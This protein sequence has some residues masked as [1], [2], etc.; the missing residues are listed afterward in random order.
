[1]VASKSKSGT[2]RDSGGSSR[3]EALS[4]PKPPDPLTERTV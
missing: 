3:P 1:M 2:N 4:L